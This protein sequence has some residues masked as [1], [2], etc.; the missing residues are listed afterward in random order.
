M[1]NHSVIRRKDSNV[2]KENTKKE[3]WTKSWK[4]LRLQN[5]T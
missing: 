3:T 5:K 1:D 2:L 4:W